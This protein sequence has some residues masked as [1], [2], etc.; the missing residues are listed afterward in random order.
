MSMDTKIEPL[1][2]YKIKVKVVN[3]KGIR[4]KNATVF[5]IC[6]GYGCS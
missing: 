3:A 1:I 5:I 6:C 4:V 2:T